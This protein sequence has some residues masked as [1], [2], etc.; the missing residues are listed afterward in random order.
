LS[1][2]SGANSAGFRVSFFILKNQT[3]FIVP[4][5]VQLAVRAQDKVLVGIR[6]LLRHAVIVNDSRHAED[7]VFCATIL[8]PLQLS[9]VV[10]D[11]LGQGIARF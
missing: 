8:K 6:C 5:A 3:P 2:S 11:E 7:R 4:F 10:R 9:A 1:S